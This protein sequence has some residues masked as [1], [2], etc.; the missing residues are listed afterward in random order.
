MPLRSELAALDGASQGGDR[1]NWHATED[2]IRD[3]HLRQPDGRLQV[4]GC[5][6]V[7]GLGDL[8]AP[9][10]EHPDYELV[11]GHDAA[12]A[13]RGGRSTATGVGSAFRV[14]VV[15]IAVPGPRRPGQGI[16]NPRA[17]PDLLGG[18][19]SATLTP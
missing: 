12:F 5:V 19:R 8:A 4:E 15:P 17:N 6:L 2:V 10:E 13:I 16:V 9:L 7:G 14:N 3:T 18:R 1:E 11:F